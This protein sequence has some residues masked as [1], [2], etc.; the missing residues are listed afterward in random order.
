M[1]DK[2]ELIK[3]FSM[4]LRRIL[5]K[6]PVDFERVQEIRLRVEQPLLM[7]Y[8][9]REFFITEEGSLTNSQEKA[10]NVSRNEILET[11]EYIGNYSLYAYEEELKQGFLTVK[12]GHRVGVAGKLVM[13]G[14]KIQ[15]IRY[16]SF[17]NIRL[18]HE[19]LGCADPVMPYVFENGKLCHTLVISPPRCGKTTLLRDMIRQISDGASGRQGLTVGVVDERS[20]IGGCYLGVPQNDLGIRTYVLDCCP[21]SLGMM[22]LLRSMSPAVIAVDELGDPGD[23]HAVEAVRNCGCCLLATV[24]GNSVEDIR[25]KP[26]LGKLTAEHFFERYVVL[27]NRPKAGWIHQIFDGRGTCLYED[28]EERC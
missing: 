12:G 25:K 16:I 5:K 27:W 20:E 15:G 7:V 23:I 19:C 3:L 1:T 9:G 22:L 13:D 6:I 10:W 17:L 2:E 28:G 24:H 21:K 26:L 8:E 14:G 11:M 4:D 18:A